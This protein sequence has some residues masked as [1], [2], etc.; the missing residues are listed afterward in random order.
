MKTSS[1]R[2]ITRDAKLRENVFSNK[3]TIV[4]KSFEKDG[5]VLTF[6]LTAIDPSIVD[7]KKKIKKLDLSKYVGIVPDDIPD[8]STEE[9][10]LRGT[11]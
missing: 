9:A 6:A 10:W 2:Q 7:K 3:E 8:I 5:R 11:D 4:I 1:F